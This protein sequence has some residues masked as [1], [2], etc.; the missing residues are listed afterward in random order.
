M[1][2]NPTQDK[3]GRQ[4]GARPGTA[5]PSRQR[6]TS[7]RPTSGC[8]SCTSSDH[9]YPE[10]IYSD[11]VTLPNQSP[12]S[13]ITPLN[14]IEALPQA[15]INIQ[16]NIQD[17]IF[18]SAQDG[19]NSQGMQLNDSPPKKRRIQT[20]INKTGGFDQT[21]PLSMNFITQY[22]SFRSLEHCVMYRI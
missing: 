13:S 15:I 11:T 7:T 10:I 4:A 14:Q 8:R 16:D 6:H 17:N 22:I 21:D 3:S 20:K 19:R 9:Q 12:I 5:W 18:H 1:L 2:D